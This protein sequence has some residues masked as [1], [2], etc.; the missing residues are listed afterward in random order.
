MRLKVRQ[1]DEPR[2][3]LNTSRVSTLILWDLGKMLNLSKPPFLHLENGNNGV[4]GEAG[5]HSYTHSLISHSLSPT[6]VLFP[7][8]Y[9]THSDH[10]LNVPG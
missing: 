8:S 9:L 1:P 7:G 5:P 10:S 2:H 6:L 3:T 4:I